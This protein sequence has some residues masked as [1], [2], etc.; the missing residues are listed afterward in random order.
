MRINAGS[1]LE[2]DR[3]NDKEV[4]WLVTVRGSCVSSFISRYCR[5]DCLLESNCQPC[6]PGS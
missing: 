4:E 3:E 2:R 6:F 5:S 1:E